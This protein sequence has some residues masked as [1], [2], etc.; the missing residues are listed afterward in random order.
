MDIIK[1]KVFELFMSKNKTPNT[2]VIA[3]WIKELTGKFPVDLIAEA[4]EQLKWSAD[5][6]PTLGKIAESI[7]LLLE[8]KVRKF[9]EGG[10]KEAQE[11]AKRCGINASYLVTQGDTFAWARSMHDLIEA[12]KKHLQVSNNTQAIE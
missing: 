1:Q 12:Y 11:M 5:D 10:S 2:D 7:E 9:M 4:V 3:Y 6:F 8:R